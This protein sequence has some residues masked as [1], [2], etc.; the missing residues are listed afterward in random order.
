MNRTISFHITHPELF[1]NIFQFNEETHIFELFDFKGNSDPVNNYKKIF[2]QFPFAKAI[3]LYCPNTNPNWIQQFFNKYKNH[4]KIIAHTSKTPLYHN[5]LTPIVITTFYK[6][7]P[8][9]YT[10]A[11]QSILEQTQ[12][13][14]PKP[15]YD[16]P[17]EPISQNDQFITPSN[18]DNL[19]PKLNQ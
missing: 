19:L 13:I 8:Q 1:K 14:K 9:C 18:N 11:I 10:E 12:P 7:Y 3:Y 2:D 16:Y 17:E 15:W 6:E 4:F 5:D